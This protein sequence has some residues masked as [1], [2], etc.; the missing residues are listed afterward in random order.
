MA[1]IEFGESLSKLMIPITLFEKLSKEAFITSIKSSTKRGPQY[2]KYY[3]YSFAAQED[4]FDGQF[5]EIR[6]FNIKKIV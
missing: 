5:F 3:F 6:I 1:T 2:L 4:K